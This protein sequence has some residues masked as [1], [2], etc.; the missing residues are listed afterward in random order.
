M[1]DSLVTGLA[2]HFRQAS[3]GEFWS[4]LV[5]AIIIGGT[6]F[7][8]ALRLFRRG[9]IIEDTP[10][11][12]VRSA[13]QG[14][15]ELDGRAELLDGE[16]IIAPL[17]GLS[18]AWYQYK[19]EEKARAHSRHNEWRTIE[20][21]RSDDLFRLVD[22]TGSCVV[23]PEGASVTPRQKEVWHGS[24]RRPGGGPKAS[25]SSRF[26]LGRYRY[27]EERIGPKD[28][29]YAIGLFKT[30]GGTGDVG[31]AAEDTR[32]L[33]REWKQDQNHLLQ[34]F[35]QNRDGKI[36]LHEWEAARR[37]ASQ[38][39]HKAR[40]ERATQ[41]GVPM[42]VHPGSHGLPYLLSTVPQEQLAA[43]YRWWAAA[44]LVLFFL[45]GMATIWLFGVRG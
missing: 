44:A 36:D 29:L 9:R 26:A 12:K 24:S 43:R 14:Y 41:P 42:M 22:D 15:V 28:P 3:D 17:T 21:G 6:G 30:V 16:P 8:F 2:E 18:C 23:D 27:T 1:A 39:V 33:L 10:T 34:C 25:G 32:L 5:L 31:S 35:D 20:K 38:Q 40:S 13:A 11:S 4:W 37:A 45:S 19:I 7:Y